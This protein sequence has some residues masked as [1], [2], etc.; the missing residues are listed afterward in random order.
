MKI[1]GFFQA[2][3]VLSV[4]S[5]CNVYDSSR[6]HPSCCNRPPR[7]TMSSPSFRRGARGETLFK[8]VSPRIFSLLLSY[9]SHMA[10]ARRANSRSCSGVRSGRQAWA[11]D[12]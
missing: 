4:V 10:K 11:R 6:T 3:E 5:C 7:L 8:S 2:R 9:A 1:P 12:R